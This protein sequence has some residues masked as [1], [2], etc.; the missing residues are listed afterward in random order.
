M[1]SPSEEHFIYNKCKHLRPL[2]GRCNAFPRD[3]TYGS[4]VL[5]RHYK[6]QPGQKN[7]IVF[8]PGE[9]TEI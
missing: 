6:A 2:S 3:I 9:P 8:E 7:T 1:S 5:F 4:G